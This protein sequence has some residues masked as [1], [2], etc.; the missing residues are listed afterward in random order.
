M[1]EAKEGCAYLEDTDER[2]FL[3][4]SQYAYTGDYT[5]SDPEKMY[6]ASAITTIPSSYDLPPY[7][8]EGGVEE[9]HSATSV[10][11][12]PNPIPEEVPL[13]F[14]NITN[15]S[16]HDSIHWG[17]PSASQSEK[18]K[19]KMK[20]D[21]SKKSKLWDSFKSK[22]YATSKLPP[23]H[24]KNHEIR[25]NYAEVFH[26]HARL[27]VFAEKY[28]IGLLKCL[29]LQKLHQA[30]VRYNLRDEPVEN[31]VDLIQYSYSNTVDLSGSTDGLRLLV[32]SYAAC[33]VED[34]AQNTGFQSLLEHCGSAAKDLVIQMLRR[35]D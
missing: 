3:L 11:L 25:E 12:E 31:I 24:Q 34:L 10:C 16:L 21:F 28:D 5:T 26:G 23:L 8:V 1:S 30:L 20:A 13:P 6:D 32:I 19:S 27:Y 15:N 29:S 22:T 4:F 17:F 35:L 7:P 9:R 14:D 18:R 33:I 2:T